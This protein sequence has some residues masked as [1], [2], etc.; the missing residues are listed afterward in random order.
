MCKVIPLF[1]MGITFS[2]SHE[3]VP[4]IDQMMSNANTLLILSPM[5][6]TIEP[7][8]DPEALR[9]AIEQALAGTIRGRVFGKDM[10]ENQL[11]VPTPFLGR[12]IGRHLNNIRTF[13]PSR[14]FLIRSFVLM[15]VKSWDDH[16]GC[17]LS[18]DPLNDEE[19]LSKNTISV[20]N[21]TLFAEKSSILLS[22][23]ETPKIPKI[24]S[25]LPLNPALCDPTQ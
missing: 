3:A 22:L 2:S 9:N 23:E 20:P 12:E 4:M 10:T 19:L 7:T 21:L 6:Q 24:L 16:W 1:M 18:Y 17:I 8:T 25:V 11:N 14:P 15:N 13:D 5:L